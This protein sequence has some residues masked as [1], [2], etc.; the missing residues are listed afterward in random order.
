MI[1]Q[2]QAVPYEKTRGS[3]KYEQFIEAPFS[4]LTLKGIDDELGIFDEWKFKDLINWVRY[5][6][7]DGVILEFYPDNYIIKNKN[8]EF[9]LPLPNTINQFIIDMHRLN[10]R[11][12]WHDRMFFKFEPRDFLSKSDV[13]EYYEL[14]LNRMNKSYELI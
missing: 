7:T 5:T 4:H 2:F 14:L 1:K 13:R 3:E 10:I 11:L 12:F 6:N 8:N 9:K